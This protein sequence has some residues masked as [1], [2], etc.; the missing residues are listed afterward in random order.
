MKQSYWCYIP[1]V[2]SVLAGFIIGGMLTFGVA[3]LDYFTELKD[4]QARLVLML[5]G[6][7]MLGN[8]TYCAKAWAK[9]I[10]EVVYKEPKYLP[11]FF[12]FIGYIT[13]I[14]GGG[15]TGVILFLIVKTGI[16]IS[17]DSAV[18]ATVSTEAA[19]VIAYIG[20][21][22]H[23]KVQDKLGDMIE[24]IFKKNPGHGPG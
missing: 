13:L 6:M 10:E 8:S 19:L 14:V 17:I 4:Q 15:I 22:Y 5:F 18:D 1:I 23:F 9:D 7:G 20:G 24:K 2:V 21:L 16:N 12:D 3:F 11:H